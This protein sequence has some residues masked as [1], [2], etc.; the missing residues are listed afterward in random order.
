M[1]L[2]FMDGFGSGDYAAKWD[3]SSGFNGN[4]AS[5]SPRV[6]GCYYLDFSSVSYLYKY[7]TASSQVFI[8]LGFSTSSSS[9]YVSFYGDAGTVQHIT[10][11][12]NS[13]GFIEIRRG[14]TSGTLLA[15]GATFVSLNVWYYMEISATISDT[16]GEVHVRLNGSSTDEISFTGDTKNGGTATDIDRVLVSVANCR[17]ADVYILNSAGTFNNNFLGDVAVRTLRPSGNGTSSQLMGSDG[18]QI[19]N[20]ALVDELPFNSADYVGSATSSQIDTYLMA[21]LPAGITTIYAMQINSQMAKDD[22]TNG[23]VRVALRSGGSLYY[24]AVRPLFTS[25]VGYYDLYETDPA[26]SARWLVSGINTLEVGM[27]VV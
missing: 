11:I 6:A 16:I 10:V 24:S 21:D 1:S 19:D 17:L 3:V 23:S 5:A 22:A 12:R 2:L 9:P 15:T 26:T 25:F 14:S 27:E 4:T 8:G 7:I 20:Y 13:S 18:D